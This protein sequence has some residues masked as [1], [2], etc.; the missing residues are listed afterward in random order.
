MPASTDTTWRRIRDE[1]GSTREWGVAVPANQY[2]LPGSTVTVTRR[3]GGTAQ[4]VLG[5]RVEVWTD[6]DGVPRYTYRVTRRIAPGVGNHR[7]AAMSALDN[8]AARV[9]AAAPVPDP[10]VGTHVL[11]LDNGEVEIYRVGTRRR[12]RYLVAHRMDRVRLTA[13]GRARWVYAGRQPFSRLSEATLLT[14]EAARRIG[15]RLGFCANCGRA[16]T[17]ELSV[18]RGIGPVCFRRIREYRALLGTAQTE[19]ATIPPYEP[20]EGDWCQDVDGHGWT[21]TARRGHTGMHVAYTSDGSRCGVAPWSSDT[22]P[23]Y[24]HRDHLQCA[25]RHAGYVCTARRG[26]A[27]PHVA[28]YHDGERCPVDPWSDTTRA[29]A[30]A[31]ARERDAAALRERMAIAA[32]EDAELEEDNFDPADLLPACAYGPDGQLTDE[33]VDATMSMDREELAAFVARVAS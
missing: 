8:A 30:R 26:H 3:D 23:P 32:E 20:N 11:N 21:C 5:D 15:A 12:S 18:D 24:E 9:E 33:W 10:P 28:Y 19:S 31:A 22:I 17:A 1:Y 13:T 25:S 29:E 6:R 16:L 14:E 2:P 27:G 7:A 4:V